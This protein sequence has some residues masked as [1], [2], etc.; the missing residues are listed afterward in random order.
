MVGGGGRNLNPVDHILIA[1]GGERDAVI[2]HEFCVIDHAT[3]IIGFYNRKCVLLAENPAG[4]QQTVSRGG[5]RHGYS[6]GS[7]AVSSLTLRIRGNQGDPRIGRRSSYGANAL[8]PESVVCHR[9][10]PVSH[11]VGTRDSLPCRQ[12]GNG[13]LLGRGLKGTSLPR[14]QRPGQ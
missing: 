14:R 12:L 2:H 4:R 11:T 10:A 5:E 3:V 1:A 7:Q 6:P 13:Q 9:F 8:G